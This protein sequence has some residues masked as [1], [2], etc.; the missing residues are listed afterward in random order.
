MMIHRSLTPARLERAVRSGMI[1][2][3][4]LGFC[5]VCGRKAQQNCEPDAEK[6]PC[7]YASC[8]A[9]EGVYG[10]EQLLLM[11]VA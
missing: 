5:I 9:P 10:A 8:N 3:T 4:F 6:Y 7:L 11:T 1:H 2:D